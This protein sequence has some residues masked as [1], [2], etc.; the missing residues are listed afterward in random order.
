MKKL[1]V[2]SLLFSVGFACAMERDKSES[3]KF[4]PE[5][6]A[7]RQK[8]IAKYEDEVREKRNELLAS[9]QNV[10]AYTSG[11]DALSIDNNILERFDENALGGLKKS[12]KFAKLILLLDEFRFFGPNKEDYEAID[13]VCETHER[14]FRKANTKRVKI[15]HQADNNELFD[16]SI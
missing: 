14:S 5:T 9:A 16:S 8:M 13:Q 11:K 2:F 6:Q 7:F 12:K 4:G 3:I 15:L 10:I 1:F